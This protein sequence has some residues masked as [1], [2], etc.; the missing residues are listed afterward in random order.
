MVNLRRL[1]DEEFDKLP[2]APRVAPVVP[3]APEQSAASPDA[4]QGLS[5]E[6]FNSLGEDAPALPEGAADIN[7]GNLAR[8]VLSGAT[9]GLDDEIVG[10]MRSLAGS[11]NAINE[12]RARKAAFESAHP[13]ASF[14]AKALG[15][16]AGSVLP[17]SWLARGGTAGRAAMAA[18]PVANT[19]KLAGATIPAALQEGAKLGAK[20]ALWQRFGDS[21]GNIPERIGKVAE[22]AP[23]DALFGA[24]LGAPFGYLG[25]GAANIATDLETAG[26]V[27]L[28]PD[29]AATQALREA[30][31]AGQGKASQDVLSQMIPRTQLTSAVQPAHAEAIINAYGT[32]MKAGGSASDAEAAA[33]AAYNAMSPMTR[34]G[35][36]VSSA[37]VRNRARAVIKAFQDQFLPNGGPQMIAAERLSGVERPLQGQMR[38][39]VRQVMNSPG[40]GLDTAAKVL[41]P[42]QEGAMQRHRDLITQTVGPADYTQYLKNMENT[43]KF[44]NNISYGLSKQFA[45]PFDIMPAIAKHAEIA[46]KTF[47]EPG[48]ALNKAG[49]DVMD[50]WQRIPKPT[51]NEPPEVQQKMLG[52][53]LNSYKQVRRSIEITRQQ[54]AK[55][56]DRESAMYLTRFKRDMDAVVSRKNRTWWRSN[57]M[58]ADD[59]RVGEAAD[60]G[61]TVSLKEGAALQE[62]KAWY[63]TA[64]PKQKAAFRRG[65]ARQ[66]HDKL[67]PMG[68]F[69]DA[70]KA[71]LTGSDVDEEGMRGLI[72][73][74]LPKKDSEK[75][76]RQM[77]RERTAL[78]TYRLD[79]GSPTGSILQEANKRNVASRLGAVLRYGNPMAVLE[80]LSSS[81]AN[82]AG[83]ARDA[84]LA[85]KLFSTS[86]GDFLDILRALSQAEKPPSRRLQR[87]LSVAPEAPVV[88]A[89]GAFGNFKEEQ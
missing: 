25:R 22:N 32:I 86:E 63:Q 43:S 5:D 76:L 67:A 49:A 9:F 80:D 78:S 2:D 21:G 83:Q 59:F 8:Q 10:G 33:V 15:A 29:A 72:Q 70:S 37:V 26:R 61:R 60:L 47:G 41:T 68:D 31:S 52:D 55:D 51:G 74:V 77:E 46:R 12:E 3:Q 64:A 30:M 85:R 44:Q 18:L 53:L 66:F 6:E 11:E 45:K 14:G 88:V 62:A 73:A 7:L 40:E 28:G 79:K 89:P 16:I 4:A 23:S 1:S 13:Y 36:P 19:G 82:S 65:L 17:V 71:F 54:L 87:A 35:T 48:R 50:W 81:M 20:A 24:A 34:A 75:F 57:K 39:L 58:A 69:H 27:G 38:S 84:A 42:R 56:G